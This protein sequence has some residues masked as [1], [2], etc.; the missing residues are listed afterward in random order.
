MPD[1]PVKH[2]TV[3]VV[4][5]VYTARSLVSFPQ[6]SDPPDKSSLDKSALDKSALDKSVLAEIKPL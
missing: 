5:S 3:T 6:F 4:D 1:Y 2:Q